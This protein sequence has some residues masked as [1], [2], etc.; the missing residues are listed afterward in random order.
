MAWEA[1]FTLAVLGLVLVALVRHWAGPDVVLIGAVALVM[2]GGLFGDGLPGPAGLVAGFGNAGL[3][4][5]AALFVVAAGLNQTGATQLLTRPLLGHPR[6]LRRAQARLMLPVVGLSAL[7]NNTPVVAM[8][9]PVVSDWSRK[10]GLSPSKLFLPL[11]YA[12][13][14]GGMCTLIG[15]STNLLVYGLLLRD[16]LMGGADPMLG[17]FTIG[18]VG[19]PV[20]VL[21]VVYCLV[22]G[23]RLLPDRKPVLAVDEANLRQYTVEMM[24]DPAGPLGGT[25]IEAAGLRQLPGLF[26]A[27]IE[28]GRQVMPAVGP[29]TVLEPGDRLVFVGVVESVNDLR[30]VRGLS[31]ATDQVFKLDTPHGTRRLVEAVVS[32]TC[33]LLGQSIREGRFRG[34]YHAAVIA[35]AR[36]GQRLSGKI[37]DIVLRPADVL[38]LEAPA[39]FV[40]AQRN[41]RDF[42]LVRA[43]NDSTPPRHDRA[44]WAIGILAAFVALVGLGWLEPLHGALLAVV[45]LGATRCLTG[46]AARQALDGRV[47][48]VIGAALGLGLA[49]QQSG[50][51]AGI[52]VAVTSLVGDH[53]WLALVAV[54][55]LTNLFTELITNNA[56]AVLVYPIA[57]TLAGDLGASFTPF[58][59]VIMIAASASF[60]TPIGYQTNL[61][62]YGPGG[63]RFTDY[64]RFGAPLNLLVAAATLLLTP[65]V[66]PL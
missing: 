65:M 58:V 22:F 50:L 5:V 49:V 24:V 43:V 52:A 42:Y 41:R 39:H 17:L 51:A 38:L 60:A 62:V 20:A 29:E 57:Q 48:L 56:A 40:E 23:G 15:T 4:T 1:W 28:R 44:G 33:P 26:L 63:Y 32:A 25:T 34:R 53:P 18:L 47:L 46:S 2:T 45:G 27:E 55:L 14:V 7:M 30:K 21:V 11:S 35:V 59:I 9:L 61:M 36:D 12:A 13:I 37:G 31:P 16:G 6:T 54:Y 64:L 66:F 3:I 8:L 10:I 19:L